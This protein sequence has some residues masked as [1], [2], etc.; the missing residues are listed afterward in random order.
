MSTKPLSLPRSWFRIVP[1]ALALLALLAGAFPAEARAKARPA[2]P[3][4][5]DDAAFRTEVQ[6][7]LDRLYAMDFA[8]AQTVFSRI[9]ARFAQARFRLEGQLVR[10]SVQLGAVSF[11][12]VLG[13]PAQLLEAAQ[14][15]GRRGRE[16]RRTGSPTGVST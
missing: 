7:G 15:E 2:A 16:G 11:P 3:S 6:E 14:L 1:A 12:D 4:I 5:L 10:P 9:E 8:A 13:T